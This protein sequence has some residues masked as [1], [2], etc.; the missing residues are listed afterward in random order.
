[1]TENFGLQK[2][3]ASGAVL[4]LG[5]TNLRQSYNNGELSY[6]PYTPQALG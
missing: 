2:G 1:M 3:F 4:D 5:Y 6:N